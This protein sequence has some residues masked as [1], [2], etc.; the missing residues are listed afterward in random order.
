MLFLYVYVKS[1]H[2]TSSSV[3]SCTVPT[4]S[5]L[6]QGLVNGVVADAV[7]NLG[8]EQAVVIGVAEAGVRIA[9]AVS[10][11]VTSVIIIE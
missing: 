10:Y 6:N 4:T 11:Q 8:A 7:R 1:H 9:V 3:I 5:N 2:S